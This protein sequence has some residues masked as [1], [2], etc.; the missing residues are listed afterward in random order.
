M[1]LLAL[2]ALIAAG[3]GSDAPEDPQAIID[4]TFSSDSKL[5]S[6]KLDLALE[7]SSEGGER[8]STFTAKVGGPF[9]TTEDPGAVPKFDL[10]ID[11]RSNAGAVPA[12]SA[13]AT[14]TGEQGFLEFMGQSYEL[15]KATFDL[16]STQL[17]STQQSTQTTTQT[18]PGLQAL[19]LDPRSWLTDLQKQENEEVGGAETLHVSGRIDASKLVRDLA[20]LGERAGSAGL[21]NARQL[22]S[23]QQLESFEQSV[24][25]AKFD[26]FTGKDD[27]IIR[28][29]TLDLAIEIPEDQRKEGQPTSFDVNARF[30]FSDVNE[31]QEIKAPDSPRPFSEL[32]SGPLGQVLGNLG[33]GSGSGDSGSRDSEDRQSGGGGSATT[34]D[35]SSGGDSSAGGEG[36]G[37]QDTSEYL[38]CVQKAESSDAVQR[39]RELLSP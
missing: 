14:S 38:D 3:C 24:K 8:P 4:R 29:M 34:P 17:R 6:G 27:F 11:V 26:L 5:E 15:D 20:E 22:P 1:I 39:C 33:R 28:R 36:A 35:P 23:D 10:N 18:G 21:P 7:L 9:E 2:A 12:I 32:T 13:G 30:G 16:I 31:P 25:E 37:S 19:G